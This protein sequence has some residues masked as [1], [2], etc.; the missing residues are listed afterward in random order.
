MTDKQPEA[1]R[2]ADELAHMDHE[3]WAVLDRAAAELR[4]LHDLLGKA[5]ALARL[6]AEKI[7]AYEAVMRQALDAL[8]VIDE[9][10]PFPVAKLTIKNL[11]EQLEGKQ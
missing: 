10:M 4:R 6:S 11:R 2:L 7:A 8:E 1:L 3:R 5:N 9:A